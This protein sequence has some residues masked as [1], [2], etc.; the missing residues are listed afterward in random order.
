MTAWKPDPELAARLED[1]IE[2]LRLR[3]EAKRVVDAEEQPDVD[4]GA[5][6]LSRS[7]L[8]GLPLPEPLIGDVLP[9]HSYGILR[10]RDHSFKSFVALDWALSLATGRPW[11]ARPV[12]RVPVL[13]IA[14]EGAYG[15]RLRI[16]AWEQAAATTIDDSWFTLRS[17][18]LNLHTPGPAFDHLLEHVEDRGY[19]LVVVDTLRKVSGRADGNGS[20]MGPVVDNLMQLKDATDNGSVLVL[21]HTDKGDNDTRGFSGIEDDADFVWHARREHHQVELEL[22]KMK[23]GPDGITLWMQ[24]RPVLDSLVL[25]MSAPTPDNRATESEDTLL[26]TLRLTFPDGAYSSQLHEASGLPKTTFYRALGALKTAGKVLNSGSHKRPFYEAVSPA[27]SGAVPS[28][29][30][31]SDLQV[32]HRSHEVPLQVPQVPRPLGSGTNGTETGTSEPARTCSCGMPAENQSLP[33]LPGC[34]AIREQNEAG[35]GR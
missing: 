12:D 34:T 7:Q 10:G 35:D 27:G 19:G 24:A 14:G 18:P 16:P 20:D 30:S 23:D 28:L 26:T 3:R 32:S 31:P 8:E 11:W 22:T 5:L 1:E 25:A 4:F 13:Y 33:H 6:F 29:D 21:T 2:L 17:Q 9:R 15:M